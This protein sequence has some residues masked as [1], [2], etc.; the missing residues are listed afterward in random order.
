MRTCGAWYVLR[1]NDDVYLRLEDTASLLFRAGPPSRI[2]GGLFVDGSSMSVP[3]S[4]TIPA[5][6]PGVDTRAW[7]KATKAWVVSRSAY[8]ADTYPNFAQGNAYVLSSDLGERVAALG[9]RKHAAGALPARLRRPVFPLPRGRVRRER[10]SR[11]T[12]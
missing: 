6:P 10:L 2:Y 5:A 9:D 7:V 11:R 4:A 12:T 3:R 8:P 1:A